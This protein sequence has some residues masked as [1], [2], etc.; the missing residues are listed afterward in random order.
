ME[1]YNEVWRQISGYEN[2]YVSNFGR[3]K[4]IKTEKI[5]KPGISSNGWFL[6]G[7]F[8]KR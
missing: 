7:Y 4:N 5:F 3:V 1:N 2:Y 8:N 6:L